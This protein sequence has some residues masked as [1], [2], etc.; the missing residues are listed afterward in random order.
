MNGE[1]KIHN[2]G[3][4]AEEVVKVKKAEQLI[5][6][7]EDP[8]L[9]LEVRQLMGELIE[10]AFTDP[11]TDLYNRRFFEYKLQQ[12]LELSKEKQQQFSVLFLDLDNFK[13]VNDRLGHA[14]GDHVLKH[15][16][17]LMSGRTDSQSDCRSFLLRSNPHRQLRD[18]KLSQPWA[19]CRKPPYS[20]GSC[21]VLRQSRVQKQGH[22]SR[23][24]SI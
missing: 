10:A 2:K 19:R 13:A 20:G 11:L 16:S 17:A 15:V 4:F 18:R 5:A 12:V 3:D 1:L 24:V 22:R 6:K 9:A 21:H 23:P 8:Q 14:Y 7:I